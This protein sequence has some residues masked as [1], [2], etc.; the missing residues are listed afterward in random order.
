MPFAN[1][2]SN[3][4]IGKVVGTFYNLT[5]TGSAAVAQPF[6][7]AML[8]AHEVGASYL[9]QHIIGYLTTTHPLFGA[10]QSLSEEMRANAPAQHE[11][12]A[13][14]IAGVA[15]IQGTTGAHALESDQVAWLCAERNGLVTQ[16]TTSHAPA[17]L[18]R[19]SR[20]K[21]INIWDTDRCD[22]LF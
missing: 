15:E 19:G 6:T 11:R 8:D 22:V 10:V 2:I 20:G 1:I 17:G 16:L 3:I 7:P 18:R 13:V 9:G 21:I 12:A 14:Q 4:G 5:T